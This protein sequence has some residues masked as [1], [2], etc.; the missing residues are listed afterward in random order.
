[1]SGAIP[2]NEYVYANELAVNAELEDRLKK[3]MILMPHMQ[4]SDRQRLA[5]KIANEIDR[6]HLPPQPPRDQY[7]AIHDAARDLYNHHEM[8]TTADYLKHLG[9][10]FEALKKVLEFLTAQEHM[11]IFSGDPQAKGIFNRVISAGI[12]DLFGT[13]R[14]Y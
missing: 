9:G 13:N 1:M 10:S 4:E 12:R 2:D 7:V 3:L 6:G 8:Q 11:D 5:N 14:S